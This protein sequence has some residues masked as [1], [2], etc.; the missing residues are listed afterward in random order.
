MIE[1]GFVDAITELAEDRADQRLQVV[2]GE[3]FYWNGST[4]RHVSVPHYAPAKLEFSGLTGLSRYLEE[5]QEALEP[6]EHALLVFAPDYVGLTSIPR[7]QQQERELRA[8][9]R[10]KLG[11]WTKAGDYMGA[12]SMLIDLL[13]MFEPTDDRERALRLLGTIRDEAVVQRE[14]DGVTQTVTARE[15]IQRDAEVNVDQPFFLAPRRSFVEIEA[16]LAPYVLRFKGGGEGREP[17]AALFEAGYGD[18]QL[19]TMYQI[20]EWLV[21]RDHDFPVLF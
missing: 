7:G 5:N 10:A 20:R 2:N 18:W 8:V 16:V 6:S 3:P 12:E 15:G 14:D 1:R 9:A 17:V 19:E 21:A 13:S 11:V 4:L